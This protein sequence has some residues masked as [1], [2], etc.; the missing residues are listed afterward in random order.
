[1]GLCV[2]NDFVTEF[3]LSSLKHQI[4]IDPYLSSQ[5]HFWTPDPEPPVRVREPVLKLVPYSVDE[6]TEA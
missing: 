6:E 1:M 3:F 2:T 5:F 4:F